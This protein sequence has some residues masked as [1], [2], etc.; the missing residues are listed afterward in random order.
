MIVFYFKPSTFFCDLG[1]CPNDCN[2]HGVCMS[3]RDISVYYGPDYDATV[4]TGG[5]GKGVEYSNWEKSSL[6]MCNCDINYFGPDCSL[7]KSNVIITFVFSI[8]F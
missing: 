7:R 1:N 4:G 8:I 5:D 2:G 6:M 3:I